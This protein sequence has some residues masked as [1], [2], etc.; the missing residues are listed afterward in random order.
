MTSNLPGDCRDSDLPG[1]STRDA[2]W[3]RCHEQ[4]CH[5]LRGDSDDCRD[6]RLE[7]LECLSYDRHMEILRALA[8]A[9]GSSMRV[10]FDHLKECEAAAKAAGV[11]LPKQR[12]MP[13]SDAAARAAFARLLK[14]LEEINADAVND[15]IEE[16]M[17][18]QG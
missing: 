8:T 18:P 14:T 9:T 5:E 1:C 10:L 13:A 6:T 12:L 4:A 2:L 7:Y 3:D 11:V 17:E 16:L 15:R